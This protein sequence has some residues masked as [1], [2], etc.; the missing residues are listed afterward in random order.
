MIRELETCTEWKCIWGKGLSLGTAAAQ[1]LLLRKNDLLAGNVPGTVLGSEPGI[2]HN[3][4]N[5]HA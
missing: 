3:R 2:D 1:M 4:G 5:N